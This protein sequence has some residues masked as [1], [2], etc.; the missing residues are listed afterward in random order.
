MTHTSNEPASRKPLRLWPGVVAVA[1][2]WLFWIGAPLVVSEQVYAMLGAV[3]CGLVVIVWW[4][5]FSR[6]AWSERL[7]AIA[8]MM[9]AVFG[10]YQVVHESMA[11]AGMG[12]MLIL[13]SLPLLSLALVAWALASPRLVGRLRLASMVAAFLLACGSL[14]L[15][16][17]GG[18]SGDGDSD[19]HWRWTPTPEER[20]L[21]RGGD[22]PLDSAR[23]TPGTPSPAPATA[24]ERPT[25]SSPAPATASGAEKLVPS[26]AIP[27]SP[28]ASAVAPPAGK[29][30]AD[31]TGFRGPKRDGT[32]RGVRIDTDWSRVPP[33]EL[34][35]RPIG[36]GWSSFAVH[37]DVFY[38]QEQRGDDE[39]VS[40][41]SLKTG[42][43]VWKHRDAARFW[44]SNSGA[45][46]R[47]TP[48]F[49]NGRVYTLGATGI[50]N[51]LNAHDGSVIWSRNA[52]A[53]TGAQV[54]GW[55]FTSSPLVVNDVVIVATSGRLA[56]YAV[57]TG[58]PRWVRRTKGGS[59][60][61]PHRVTIGGVEQILM[62][63]GGGATSVAAS[64]GTEL[65]D[66]RWPESSGNIVQPAQTAD[67]DVLIGPID[68][69]GG[70]F[71]TRRIAVAHGPGGW[72]AQERWT[73][74]GLK[75]SFSDYV[76]HK[77]HA[78]GFDGSILACIDL[79]DGQRRWKGGRYGHGQLVLLAEQDLLLVL[80]EDGELVLV[81]ATPDKF[82]ELTA[83]VPAIEGKTWNHPV[84]VGDVLLVRNAEEMAAFR[85][86]L[87]GR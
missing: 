75:P 62:L 71:A 17:T 3:V 8:L 12:Y 15:V 23:G 87:A 45:G 11:T 74:R 14:T 10:T 58:H 64:D 5:F 70:G 69:G 39:L 50:V 77:G 2:Q 60:S 30:D 34:W 73:T 68:S 67:G 13:Y 76:V 79:T 48:T 36:P 28:P 9:V 52:A 33:V 81:S 80:S 85:L 61:S 37:G 49:D 18:I 16:R 22:T 72:T 24:S 63:N 21:A 25:V 31:W 46:P 40:A 44:E 35:R 54:P 47:G 83:R 86:S 43:P 56:A 29:T 53:D 6:A 38:T 4:L 59:Y 26:P 66:Y 7:G 42:A 27:A 51:A 65:W 19:L 78:F 41:Y 55:G 32:I 82:T 57:D 20:L 84:L 1:L